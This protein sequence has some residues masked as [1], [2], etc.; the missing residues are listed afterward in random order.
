MG[1]RRVQVTMNGRRD[2]QSASQ[3]ADKG[4]DLEKDLYIILYHFS[5]PLVGSFFFHVF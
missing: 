5:C 2:C 1:G 4:S 3:P